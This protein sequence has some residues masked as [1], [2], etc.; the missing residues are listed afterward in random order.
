MV[1]GFLFPKHRVEISEK[2]HYDIFLKIWNRYVIQNYSLINGLY[3]YTEKLIKSS[4]FVSIGMA[5][6]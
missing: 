4:T 2:L 1:T 6:D 3:A 5:L